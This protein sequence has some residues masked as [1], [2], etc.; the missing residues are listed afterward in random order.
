MTNPREA[1]ARLASLWA[2]IA[3]INAA[4]ER[5]TMADKAAPPDHTPSRCRA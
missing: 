2:A 1:I 5:P 3:A 4:T